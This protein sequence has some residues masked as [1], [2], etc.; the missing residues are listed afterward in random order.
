M[1]HAGSFALVAFVLPLSVHATE[2]RWDFETAPKGW[3]Q[4]GGASGVIA[5]PGN[6]SNHVYKIAATR[7]HHTRL[8]LTGSQEWPDFVATCRFRVLAWHGEPPTV[9]L[10]ARASGGFR[11]L[12][13]AG[14]QIRAFCWHGKG[15]ANPTIAQTHLPTEPDRGCWRH[16]KL[17]CFGDYVFARVW[18][19]GSPEPT[20]QLSGQSPGLTKGEFALGVW[21]SPRTPSTAEVL[22]DDVAF[23]P[24]TEADVTP[25]RLRVHP[26]RALERAGIPQA[27][28][29]RASGTIGVAT[30]TTVVAFDADNGE[31][32][33]VVHRPAGRDFVCPQVFRP[34]FDLV[35]T[36]PYA[37][38]R[39]TTSA[40]AFRTVNTRTVDDKTI[41]L[42][43][44][45]HAWLPL[46]ARVRATAR[47]DGM[48]ALRLA[49]TNPSDWA[50]ATIRFPGVAWR[51]KLGDHAGDDRLVLPWLGG[52]VLPA[53]GRRG[54]SRGADYP[55]LALAQFTA[56]YDAESGVYLAAYDPDGHC[57]RWDLHTCADTSVEMNLGHL[58]PE[59]PTRDASLP[60]DVVLGTFAGDW[61]D[62]ADRYKQW[63]VHQPWCATRLDRRS[64]IPSFLKRGTGVIITGIQH[65][66]GRA[67]LIGRN[68]E[69]LPELVRRYRE[70]TELASVIF[71]PYGWENRGTWAGINYLPAV[72]SNEAWVRAN[73]A[74]RAQGDR[75]A[76]LTSGFWWVTKRQKTGSGPAFDDTADFERRRGMVVHNPDGTPWTQDYYQRLTSHGSW[77]GLSAT[78]CHGSAAARDTMRRIFLDVARL[79]TSLVSFDQEIGGG[80]RAPCY[81]RSHG[82]PPGHGR[83]MWTDFR[84]LCAEI[85]KRGKPIQPELGLFLE[86]TSELAI[87]VMAT[88]WS[89]QFGEVDHGAIGARGVGLFSYLYHEY[90]TAIGAACVQGQG[91]RGTRPSA[92]LRCRVMANNLV[93][94]LIP[95]PFLHHVPLE[96]DD[97]WTRPV[98]RAY[99]S[100]CR[101]YARFPEYLVL[102][103][104]QHPPKIT[105]PAVSAWFYR[106]DANGTPL[107]RGG[108]KVAKV[109]VELPT[110]IAGSFAA[111]DGSVGT[112]IVN[113]TDA[114]QSVSLSLPTPAAS[115]VLYDARRKELARWA[116]LRANHDI[117]L[118]LEPF[119]TRM[120]VT[121]SGAGERPTE[122]QP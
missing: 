63:A 116:R 49:I 74:L 107:R 7:P 51:P 61:R 17:V 28:T 78:L 33:H 115:A 90:V 2:R 46:T 79:G 44:A 110:V 31:L 57:K 119:G 1:A 4:P 108:P 56:L 42:S 55:G 9:Y 112:V 102:G 80:Q 14:S 88:Y 10:Y 99:F 38:A 94:G 114:A 45:D 100:Y 8:A 120:L 122:T 41:E 60:Y 101:P 76:F 72:P 3:R 82:H 65:E 87:P 69:R 37:G 64:D 59:V 22:I 71:V 77:R 96:T 75:T 84:D 106:H 117:P 58:R 73:A 48:V 53:P 86:N 85:L 95:G 105:C 29:F 68:L 24:L 43:F 83:W 12:S 23:R 27:G 91:A 89:R 93:R 121:R 39:Q 54:Q 104:T 103:A 113:T 52:S 30:E 19:A 13:I 16:V 92:S 26:R 118:S 32:A 50:I 109:S 11:A 5:E 15:R 6:P 18:A 47:A 66:E 70:R 67:K 98:S 20:W 35:L 111:R 25:L 21:T 97:P 40:A 36:K 62:A 34:L 81:A